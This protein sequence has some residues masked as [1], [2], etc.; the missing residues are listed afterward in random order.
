METPSTPNQIN[1]K[2]KKKQVT[3]I[4]KEKNKYKKYNYS[5]TDKKEINNA[6][7]NYSLKLK[8]DEKKNKKEELLLN[9]KYYIKANNFLK[10]INEKPF[11]SYIE[12]SEFNKNDII[13]LLRREKLQF[14][15]KTVK[16]KI[17]REKSKL[18]YFEKMKEGS[19]EPL[20]KLVTLEIYFDE[21][22]ENIKIIN[23]LK[24][25]VERLK[26]INEQNKKKN[27]IYDLIYLY[28]SPIFIG[29]QNL[30]CYDKI[31]YREEIEQILTI[32]KKKNKEFKCLF[33]CANENSLSNVFE[34]METKILHISSHGGFDS[35]TQKYSLIAE[36]AENCGKMQK[37]EENDLIKYIKSRMEEKRQID[38]IILLTCY[39]EGFKNLI[40]K[41]WKNEYPN[42]IIYV[43][44]PKVNPKEEGKIDDAVCILFTKYFYNMLTNGNS[45]SESFI[46]AKEEIKKDGNIL[47]SYSSNYD[48][49]SQEIEKLKI[50]SPKQK[51]DISKDK[52]N[53]P[54]IYP[55]KDNKN[56][57]ISINKNVKANF[58]GKKYKS[59]FGRVDIINKVYQ[60]LKENKCRFT[61]I[62]GQRDSGKL[63]FAESLCVFLFERE[64]INDYKIFFKFINE[65]IIKD[66]IN[67]MKIYN[68]KKIIVTIRIEEQ[69]DLIKNI[70]IKLVGYENF[71]FILIVDKENI[72]KKTKENIQNKMNIKCNFFDALLKEDGAIELFKA[73][74]PKKKVDDNIAGEIITK[75][76]PIQSIKEGNK[77]YDPKIIEKLCDSYIANNFDKTK[78]KINENYDE[79]L[80]NLSLD[81]PLFSYLF[82]LSKM[83]LGLPDCFVYLIFKTNFNH[84]LIRKNTCNKWNYVNH[85]IINQID[86]NISNFETLKKNSIK[87]MLK[88]LRLY[89]KIL[90]FNIEKNRNKINY[91]DE[92]IHFIFNS[93]NDEGI[94]KSNIKNIDDE[95]DIDENEFFN[96]DFNIQN[97]AENINYLINYLV[98]EIKYYEDQ[99]KFIDYLLEILLLFPSFFFLK[100]ICKHYIIKCKNFCQT[101]IDHFKVNIENFNNLFDKRNNPDFIN[102]PKI[103]NK[104]KNN[105]LKTQID[106]INEKRMNLEEQIQISKNNY[107]IWKE[108]YFI[109]SEEQKMKFI[110]QK[111]KL[112][113]F[114]YSISSEEINDFPKETNFQLELELKI[115]KLVKNDINDDSTEL[116][117]ILKTNKNLPISE[118]RKALLY[119]E[120]SR[121]YYTTNPNKSKSYFDSALRISDKFKFQFLQNRINIDLC[122]IFLN[123]FRKKIKAINALKEDNND[124]FT[125]IK[126]KI[127]ILDS[128]KFDNLLKNN[129]KLNE[130][131]ILIREKLSKLIKPNIIMLNANPLNN[132]FSCLSSEI[133][134]MLNN[135]YYILEQLMKKRNSKKIQSYIKIKSYILNEKNLEDSLKKTGEILIIQSDDFTEN[136]DIVLESDEGISQKLDSGKFLKII[137]EEKKIKYKVVILSFFNCSK[138]VE[139]LEKNKVEYEYLIYFKPTDDF[140]KLN[141]NIKYFEFNRLCIEFIIYFISKYNKENDNIDDI[142]YIFNNKYFKNEIKC[143]YNCKKKDDLNLNNSTFNLF[144]KGIFFLDPLIDIEL[145]NFPKNIN[146]NCYAIEI[147]EIIKEIKGIKGYTEI[148]CNKNKKKKYIEI[149][150]EMIKYFYRH[151][152]FL[153]Y[154]IIDFDLYF[155]EGGTTTPET[156]TLNDEKMESDIHG[157]SLDVNEFDKEGSESDLKLLEDK[158][159]NKVEERENKYFYLIYN[160]MDK[161]KKLKKFLNDLKKNNFCYM[162]IYVDDDDDEKYFNEHAISNNDDLNDNSNVDISEYTIFDYD[163][164]F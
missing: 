130:E 42:Y 147:L 19:N 22:K 37:I 141:S 139:F 120:L 156:E 143:F 60:D 73:L 112:S 55:F 94:W 48:K 100:K 20:D 126:K 87:Y 56:G 90:Y 123:K 70:I 7:I 160:C 151:K 142:A 46:K 117:N 45:I 17:K 34:F 31:S 108:L 119:Y 145:N 64:I 76:Y 79:N 59:I 152:T 69:E 109:S 68:T 25:E 118:K 65:N 85:E 44:V 74:C 107:E 9:V 91:P 29:T 21:I 125:E 144:N 35:P 26:E 101:C 28:A 106:K 158:K 88:A 155:G 54:K 33:Q 124:L 136:G 138:F 6:K 83:P 131:K 121:K 15:R 3:I 133:Y 32:M 96:N 8:N 13:E 104:T 66:Y 11:Y 4:N 38:L 116:E 24:N 49:L 82:L 51:R 157:E 132:G 137:K 50:I 99:P 71:Y 115:L 14:Y 47:S 84:N 53:E 154:F 135:Q 62:Y 129:E 110:N 72:E 30:P 75:N 149:G 148:Y 97:H 95:K 1:N 52:N 58:H 41:H 12:K 164:I 36:N 18:K 81:E 80:L 89:C 105:D 39:S 78:V 63:Y 150:I 111:A 92:N 98:K 114:L 16:I 146:N 127:N 93:Y 23:R 67:S 162:V 113:L 134:A 103:E 159:R 163:L 140:E 40:I 10:R 5:T 122:Y 128:L 61:I 102:N 27:K 86:K 161:N 2:K 57:K 77:K 153:Q 43:K